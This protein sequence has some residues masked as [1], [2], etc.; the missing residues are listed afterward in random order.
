M[1]LKMGH[2]LYIPN[3]K[4]RHTNE[5]RNYHLFKAREN[6]YI[7][8]FMLTDFEVH[9]IL[10]RAKRNPEDCKGVKAMG[11]M[12]EIRNT[13]VR[14]IMESLRYYRVKV[15]FPNAGRKVLLLTWN[16]Y[17]YANRRAKRNPEDLQ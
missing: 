17:Y 15:W 1:A 11:Q 13:N 6:S 16:E 5:A 14:N 4:L 7:I 9:R 3:R 2:V 12:D 10:K 8:D